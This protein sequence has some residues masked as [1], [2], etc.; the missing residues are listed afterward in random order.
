MNKTRIA[1]PSMEPGGMQAQ[2]SGHFGRCDLFTIVDVENGEIKAVSTLQNI[3]HSEGGCLEPVKLLAG[4][5]VNV[6][7]VGGMGMRPLLGFRQ[8]G[9]DVFLGIG[10]T[11]QESIEGYLQ[12]KLIPMSEEYVCGGH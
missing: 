10:N 3:E 8:V 2:R 1:V 6:I 4:H 7:I 12:E 5:G 11:V 9:I